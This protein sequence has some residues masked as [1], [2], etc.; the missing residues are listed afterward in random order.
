[1]KRAQK[2]SCSSLTDAGVLG[3]A[4]QSLVSIDHWT[5]FFSLDGFYVMPASFPGIEVAQV[6]DRPT[7]QPRVK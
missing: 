7:S 5:S 2:T 4:M 1:M 6:W 3:V